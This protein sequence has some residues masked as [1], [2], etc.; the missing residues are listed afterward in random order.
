MPT[1]ST[2]LAYNKHTGDVCFLTNFRTP[3]NQLQTNKTYSSRGFLVAEYVKIRDLSIDEKKKQ[4]S[5]VE[6]YEGNLKTIITRGFNIVYGNAFSREFKYFQFKNSANRDMLEPLHLDQDKVYGMSNGGLDEWD[7]VCRGK[8]AFS[9]VVDLGE[10][11]VV[12]GE[13]L[14]KVMPQMN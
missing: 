12:G 11:A 4:F 6:E 1:K 5:T 9:E 2:W 7:K 3:D 14:D 8:E 10:A 13:A